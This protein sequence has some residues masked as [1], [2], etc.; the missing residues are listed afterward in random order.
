[1]RHLLIV[2]ISVVLLSCNISSKD[3]KRSSFAKPSYQTN[4]VATDKKLSFKLNSNIINKSNC[5]IPY[6]S[7]DSS[8]YL[9][10]L[11]GYTNKICVFNIDSQKLINTIELQQRGPN[12]VG[13]V[14]GFEVINSDSIYIT[15]NFRKRLYLI[16]P[17][18]KL[19]SYLDYSKYKQ[20]YLINAPNT[21][22]LENMRIGFKDSKIY[23][24]YYPGY[25]EGN[26]KRIPPEN[27]RFVAILD[28]L[29][30]TA[31]TLNIGFPKDYWKKSYYPTFFGFFI[32]KE[33][34][35]I[36]YMYNNRVLTSTDSE[37]WKSYN[38]SSKYANIGKYIPRGEG[39]NT[40]YAR[41]VAD[42]Y[43]NIFYRFVRHKQAIIK[44]RTMI[45]LIR[46][47]QKF[48]IIIL[49]NK[50]EIIGET[51]FPADIY[52]MHGYFITKDGLYLSLSNPFNHNYNEDLLE[53]QLFNL[54]K[55]EE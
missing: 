16:N 2:I 52:D 22:S 31:E 1:M 7:P 53:F 44:G 54:E 9:Y 5:I 35:Y 23:L 33:I 29:N 40:D 41:L 25:D 37:N 51:I 21:R 6:T 46:Y 43:K 27:I 18:G 30:K 20:D 34:F 45:D 48:S 24:P 4:L 49:N 11:S 38:I 28:T 47:P 14:N 10:Y 12:G 39:L 8:N 15:S 3:K 17:Q 42:P 32:Y 13:N 50:L 36:N 55:D 19:I 26:Y